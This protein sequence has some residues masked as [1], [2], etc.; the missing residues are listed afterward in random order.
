MYS[1]AVAVLVAQSVALSLEELGAEDFARRLHIPWNTDLKDYS[2]K[3]WCTFDNGLSSHKKLWRTDPEAARSL[4]EDLGAVF[5]YVEVDRQIDDYVSSAESML[6]GQLTWETDDLALQ[7]I[8]ARSRAPMVWLLANIKGALL[9]STSNRS[10]VALGYATMDGDTA[11][12]SAGR[13]Y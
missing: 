2:V 10:E 5:H 6:G 11:E 13:W 1:S 12:L 7:N 3:D 8:Q 4:A 9:L